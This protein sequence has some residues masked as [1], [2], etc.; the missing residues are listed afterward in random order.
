MIVLPF[1]VGRPCDVKKLINADV[2]IV[3]HNLPILYKTSCRLMVVGQM[4]HISEWCVS[5]FLQFC[6]VRLQSAKIVKMYQIVG[7]TELLSSPELFVFPSD[8]K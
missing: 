3:L 7:W 6:H 4:N 5:P 8:R 1:L 2:V